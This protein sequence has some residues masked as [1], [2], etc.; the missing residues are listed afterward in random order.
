MMGVN[1]PCSPSK[2]M[3]LQQLPHMAIPMTTRSR[4]RTQPH[5]GPAGGLSINAYNGVHDQSG[6][7]SPGAWQNGGPISGRHYPVVMTPSFS[8]DEL[9][10]LLNILTAD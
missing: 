4:T 5:P 3:V 2:E 8:Q 9:T 7:A 6:M 10:V 1:T